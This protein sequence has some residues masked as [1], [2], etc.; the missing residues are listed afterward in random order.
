MRL[1]ENELGVIDFQG[2]VQ[3]PLLYD[4]VSLLKD[5]YVTWPREQ[6][7]AW[8]KQYAQQHPVLKAVDWS[9]CLRWFDWI[10]MQRHLKCLGIFTRLWLRD[11]KP[12]YL[13]AIPATFRY[14]LDV[15]QRYPAFEQHGQW[16]ER[17]VAPVLA[18]KAVNFTAQTKASPSQPV[19]P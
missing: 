8:L 2:A 14:V 10:G 5:C 6:V 17:R 7:E 13:S 3:G 16:L 1:S 12:Q 19:T 11:S 15:C 4:I 18:E 9:T